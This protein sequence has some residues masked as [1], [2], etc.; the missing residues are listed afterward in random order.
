MGLN[1]FGYEV[2]FG[3]GVRAAE[4]VLFTYIKETYL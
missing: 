2:T 3:K 1:L 4:E